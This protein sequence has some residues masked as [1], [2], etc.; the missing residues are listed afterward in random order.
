MGKQ[1]QHDPVKV[2][3]VNRAPL[4]ALLAADAVSLT[5]N[6]F[7]RVAVPWFVLA[8]GGTAAQ[9]G[10]TIFVETVALVLGAVFGG[11]FVDRLGHR[12]ASVAAD[13][14]SGASVA[15]V[16]VFYGLGLLP[17]WL[18]LALVFVGALLDAP[19]A[20]ARQAL[21]PD[22]AALAGADLSR[23]NA[24]YSTAQ[25]LAVL[26]GPVV[27]GALIAVAGAEGVISLNAVSFLA[28]AVIVGALASAVK[29]RPDPDRE[30]GYAAELAEG[31]AF[32]W[33]DRLLRSLVLGPAVIHAVL[34]P[35]FYVVLPVYL[36]RGAQGALGLGVLFS[37]YGGG[38][39]LG[40]VGFGV[41]GARLARRTLYL[42]CLALVTLA[43]ASLAALPPL[44]VM[45]VASLLVGLAVGPLGPLF[46]VVAQERTPAE[47]RGRV[48]GAM[49][50]A[51]MVALPLGMLAAGFL[52]E[53]APVWLTIV[54]SAAL[55][56]IV[57][58]TQLFNPSLHALNNNSEDPARDEN[59]P[60]P[61]ARV[62][63]GGRA[64]L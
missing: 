61:R 43:G 16:P 25:R 21:L 26:V 7:T 55:C 36:E 47:L 2:R 6:A 31:L 53:L 39:V 35:V 11:V 32:F 51:S 33:R 14:A 45:V 12:R 57:T 34:T 20:A 23:A 10:L 64:S 52:L 17:F 48:F 24:A 8:T 54:S 1:K 30:R 58:L 56:G 42:L 4:L 50:A 49:G 5:G 44:P 46:G 15:L 63:E 19:G 62:V 37:A 40:A 59:V 27:G 29:R 60:S 38:A 18:L 3:R 9:T 41:V 22:A 13:L 28:S